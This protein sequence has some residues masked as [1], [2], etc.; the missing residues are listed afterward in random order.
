MSTSCN[1]GTHTYHRCIL[2][3][4]SSLFKEHRKYNAALSHSSG[5][6]GQSD[7][8]CASC[9]YLFLL[10]ESY[11]GHRLAGCSFDWSPNHLRLV[12]NSRIFI[13]NHYR[14]R[15]NNETGWKGLCSALPE[16]F[17]EC[18]CSRAWLWWNQLHCAGINFPCFKPDFTPAMKWGQR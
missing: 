7:A 15:S 5:F 10:M 17:T 6:T 1:F 8:Q 18:I 11:V 14:G 4:W 16:L 3:A 9:Y 2:H 12:F 13:W